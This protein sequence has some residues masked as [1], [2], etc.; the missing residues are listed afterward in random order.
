MLAVSG[1]I[2][3]IIMVVSNVIREIMNDNSMDI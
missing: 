2:F 1:K 3:Y